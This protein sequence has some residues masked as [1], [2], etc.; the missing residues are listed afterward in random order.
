MT[1]YPPLPIF[2]EDDKQ[3]GEAMLEDILE[4]SLLHR[5][6]NVTVEDENGNVLLQMRGPHVGTNPNTWDFATAGYVDLGEDYEQTA[7]RELSEELG[8][9]KADLQNLGVERENLRIDDYE[10][11]RF[12]GRFKA[13]IPRNTK[14]KLEEGEV[15]DV[16]WFT[17]QELRQL[18]NE[19]PKELTPYFRNWLIN[20]YFGDENNQH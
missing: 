5:V 6:V 12:V 17:R 11:K 8:I 13:V 20:H 4:K 3:V 18:L 15:A 9:D 10:V 19:S 1:K 2:D 14:L 16:R 7:N